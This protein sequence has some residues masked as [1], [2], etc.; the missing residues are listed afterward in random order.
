VRKSSLS[1]QK[2]YVSCIN[3][4]TAN[5]S[6]TINYHF[7][8][9]FA[10]LSIRVMQSRNAHR[11]IF[12]SVETIES[13]ASSGDSIELSPEAILQN[14]NNGAVRVIFTAFNQLNQ[15]LIPVKSNTR[16][17]N[18]HHNSNAK[19]RFINSR[20]IAA[21]LGRGRHIEL[22]Q[23]VQITF[24]HLSDVDPSR[25]RPECVYWDYVS[26]AWSDDGCHAV[27]S[28]ITHTQCSCN[29]LTNFALLM[30]HST[31]SVAPLNH[32]G[33]MASKAKGEAK[34]SFAAHISTIVASVATLI[35]L[36]VII[37][38][39]AMAWRRYKVSSQCRSALQNSGLPCFHKGKEI[40]GGD[41]DNGNNKGN[42]YTVTPKL[43][44]GGPGNGLNGSGNDLDEV[45]DAQQFFEH[46]INL[47]KNEQNNTRTMTMKR[48]NSHNLND[49][50]QPDSSGVETKPNNLEQQK[51]QQQQQQHHHH[52]QQTQSEIIYP[53][54]TNYARALS[55]YNHIY[56]EID[57][58]D[59]A[60]QGPNMGPLY[61]PLT[62]SETYLMSTMSDMSEDNY[63]YL[64][65]LNY[66][67]DVSRQSSSRE[68][69]PLIRPN[70]IHNN[71]NE[72]RNL[73]HT[74]SGVLH[75][76][77]VRIA[78]SGNSSSMRGCATLHPIRRNLSA[79][80][81][82]TLARMGTMTTTG[83]V[84]HGQPGEVPL[85]VA[86]MNGN[87]FVRLNFGELN[88][89]IPSMVDQASATYIAST[90]SDLGQQAPNAALMT[91][92]YLGRHQQLLRA[93]GQMMQLQPV[94]TT[95]SGPQVP[96]SMMPPQPPQFTSE[97]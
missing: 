64:S 19:K 3:N 35:S 44:A 12:P 5:N 62:H 54:R 45:A 46:M 15:L 33:L 88:H 79:T 14:G 36:A 67:S 38:F 18:G 8:F 96:S 58:A 9:L 70:A 51:L 84:H 76:Q 1:Q 74:I 52:H 57:P 37:F 90:T 39:I 72:Q 89:G 42:F 66:N 10:V 28:N 63:N 41:K 60:D 40:A 80:N 4:N 13:W 31:D 77:S 91:S 86:T 93:N 43:N 49:A 73:L 50:G 85:Q 75:S 81:H 21:S 17:M 78:P 68:T 82:H 97:M 29:H 55:P 24:R 20:V 7:F 23:P 48:S 69:R 92:A 56:M 53:K 83:G 25:V 87:E 6:P 34:G 30:S 95:T 71:F 27:L 32:N 11:Q 2:I 16:W 26:N 94:V 65:G 22:P 61:E 47:Q 59:P